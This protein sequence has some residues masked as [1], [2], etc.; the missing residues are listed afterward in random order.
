MNK[1]VYQV[2][3]MLRAT[4]THQPVV[5]YTKLSYFFYLIVM[6]NTLPPVA[7][8]QTGAINRCMKTDRLCPHC[9]PFCCE[10]KPGNGEGLT[11]NLIVHN[12]LM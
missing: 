7:G 3:I 1:I 9:G 2:T 5:W 4:K 12:I 11:M 6:T 8:N 10:A